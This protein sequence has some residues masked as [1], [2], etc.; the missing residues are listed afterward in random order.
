MCQL[1]IANNKYVPVESL[2]LVVE[3][4]SVKQKNLTPTATFARNVFNAMSVHFRQI[5]LNLVKTG[6]ICH[7]TGFSLRPNIKLHY[8]SLLLLYYK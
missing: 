3:C 1:V 2:A 6:R 8:F 5:S 4:K 7:R